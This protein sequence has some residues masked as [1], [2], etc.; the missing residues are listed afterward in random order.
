MVQK[1]DNVSFS[2]QTQRCDDPEIDA[3]LAVKISVKLVPLDY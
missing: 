2:L 1:N 3:G